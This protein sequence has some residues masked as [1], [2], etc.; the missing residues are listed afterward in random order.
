MEARCGDREPPCAQLRQFPRSVPFE[1]PT[2]E[3]APNARLAH[4]P[5]FRLPDGFGVPHPHN[6][7]AVRNA[8]RNGE[9]TFQSGLK[10]RP[11][12]A[13]VGA[14][15]SRCATSKG[16]PFGGPSIWPRGWTFFGRVSVWRLT[17]T[18]RS[19]TAPEPPQ[20]PAQ[21]FARVSW[22]VW[23]IDSAPGTDVTS[24]IEETGGPGLVT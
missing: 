24:T 22:D 2:S 18:P 13:R 10:S 20:D 16:P 3:F 17:A 14:E 1:P 19:L 15:K 12:Q 5:V 23:R 6:R 4:G 9:R 7:A 21:A 8:P 11:K